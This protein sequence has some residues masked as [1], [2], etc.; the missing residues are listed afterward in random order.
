MTKLV[1]VWAAIPYVYDPPLAVLNDCAK[2]ALLPA[3]LVVVVP[4]AD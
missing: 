2:V 4:V 3:G 1:E